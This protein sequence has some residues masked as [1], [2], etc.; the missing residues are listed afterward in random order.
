[1]GSTPEHSA[2]TGSTPE[3]STRAG[4]NPEIPIQAPIVP[5]AAVGAADRGAGERS[6]ALCAEHS[7]PIGLFRID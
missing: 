4:S 3:L 1:M 6:S 5:A 2:H 7:E